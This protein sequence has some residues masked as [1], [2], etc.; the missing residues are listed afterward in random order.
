MRDLKLDALYV[1]CPGLHR[2]PMG[3][4]VEAVPLW[5]GAAGRRD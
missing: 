1:V 5:G 4:G 2:Y 3:A